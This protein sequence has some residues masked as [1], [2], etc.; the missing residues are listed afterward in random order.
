MGKF[1][2][3]KN[4]RRGP[5]RTKNKKAKYFLYGE[6]LCTSRLYHKISLSKSNCPHLK[7]TGILKV[8]CAITSKLSLK[9]S[10]AGINMA[11]PN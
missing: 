5:I 9:D 4:F 8:L 2:S 1:L 7:A 3:L 10:L 6:S 11:P